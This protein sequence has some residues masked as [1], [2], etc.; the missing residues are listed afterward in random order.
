MQLMHGF[1]LIR[2]PSD[3]GALDY[4]QLE[5]TPFR[6]KRVPGGDPGHFLHLQIPAASLAVGPTVNMENLRGERFYVDLEDGD[7]G[8][9]KTEQEVP[10][11]LPSFSMVGDVLERAPVAPKAPSVPTTKSSTTGFPAHRKR[12]PQSRF[13]QRRAGD[14]GNSSTGSS[15]QLSRGGEVEESGMSFEAAD[16][17]RID[18][19]NKQKIASMSP[20]EIEREQQELF[21]SLD[22]ALIQKLLQRANISEIDSSKDQSSQPAQD[23]I[24]E[25]T[26]QQRKV[27]FAEP[28]SDSAIAPDLAVGKRDA[29]DGESH[30]TGDAAPQ[31]PSIHFP[32]PPPTA[33]PDP[34]DPDFLEHLHDKYFPDLA[35]D[36]GKLAWMQPANE[37]DTMSPYHPS[38]ISLPASALRFNF[39]GEL[40]PPKLARQIP[41]SEG[42]HHHGDAPE[43]AGYTI[44]ELAHLSRSSY[45]PQRCMAYRTLGRLLYR[46]GTGGFGYEDDE[47]EEIASLS[48]G[49]WECVEETKVL[50][51]MTAE[52]KKESGHMSARAY[53]QEAVWNWQRG[54]GRKRQAR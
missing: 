48:R 9:T 18:E 36:P 47:N 39:R 7:E 46:L 2:Q 54:G 34:S 51:T 23:E 17:V 22:P 53:A 28:D 20:A 44:P 40:L 41:V 13:K 8:D 50:E 4:D 52:A 38:Q 45:A 21:S 43:A 16:R 33:E 19:E 11:H 3:A 42:L 37:D 30:T 24:S 32:K 5:R 15:S 12:N 26:E 10:A 1:D 14:D 6:A 35:H 49:M 27:K 31:P 29:D 25:R